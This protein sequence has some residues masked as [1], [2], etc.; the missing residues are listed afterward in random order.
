[1]LCCSF[2]QLEGK[3]FVNSEQSC[4]EVIFEISY[5]LLCVFLAMDTQGHKLTGDVLFAYFLFELH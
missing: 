2:P 4:Y 1:M 5:C 3:S